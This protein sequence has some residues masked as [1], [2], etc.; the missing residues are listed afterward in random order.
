[1]GML[2]KLSIRETPLIAE[3]PVKTAYLEPVRKVR[4]FKREPVSSS[5]QL[6]ETVQRV[7]K[8]QRKGFRGKFLNEIRH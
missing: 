6:G 3:R 1:L 8:G 4:H 5:V 2:L 7:L